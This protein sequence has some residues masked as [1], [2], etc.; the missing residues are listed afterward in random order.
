M[1]SQRVGLLSNWYTHTH[2]H[3]PGMISVNTSLAKVSLMANSKLM[4][5]GYT[6]S[7]LM[8]SIRK[9]PGKCINIKKKLIINSK[10]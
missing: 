3:C 9:L 6:L 7:V 4:D 5:G 2:T 8:G 1:R 10:E